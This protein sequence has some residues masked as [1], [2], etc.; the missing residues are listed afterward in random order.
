MPRYVQLAP[1]CPTKPAGETVTIWHFQH[2]QAI[3]TQDSPNFRELC[4]RI[5]KMLGYMP[6]RDDIEEAVGKGG[7]LQ[8]ATVDIDATG[9]RKFRRFR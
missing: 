1:S 3:V 9:P 7:A 6:K 8:L 5:R 2:E 4:Q